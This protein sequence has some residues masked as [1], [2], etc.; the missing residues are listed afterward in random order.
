MP[1]SDEVIT[2]KTSESCGG[3]LFTRVPPNN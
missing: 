3:T 2:R 1:D